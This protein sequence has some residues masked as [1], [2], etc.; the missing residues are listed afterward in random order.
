MVK[1]GYSLSDAVGVQNAMHSQLQVIWLVCNCKRVGSL[2]QTMSGCYTIYLP[3]I[4]HSIHFCQISHVTM[5]W[6]YAAECMKEQLDS[7]L[8]CWVSA[9]HV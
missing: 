7:Q 9:V 4:I 3:D 2:H 5:K 8:K 1:D 6:L